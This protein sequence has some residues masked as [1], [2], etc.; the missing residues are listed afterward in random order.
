M[1]D[2]VACGT[3]L[4]CGG[5]ACL[6]CPGADAVACQSTNP[7][8]LTAA[9]SCSSGV[10]VCTDKTFLPDGTTCGTGLTCQAG[11]CL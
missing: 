11:V 7:C 5:G 2:G 9:T 4:V 3:N 6:A 10:P 8:A 1:P